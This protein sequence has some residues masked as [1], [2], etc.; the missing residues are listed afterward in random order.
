MIN[1]RPI[2]PH[3]ITEAKYLISAVAQRIFVPEKSVQE[4][5]DILEEEG[6]LNDMDNLSLIHI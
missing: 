4:F 6:E 2:Q 3:Q 5:Y 1:I